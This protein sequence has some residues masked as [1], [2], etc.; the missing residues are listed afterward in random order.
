ML[1][2]LLQF[3]Q[4]SHN[5][6]L[7][8]SKLYTTLQHT[9]NF[10]RFLLNFSGRMLTCQ[11]QMISGDCIF[12]LYVLLRYWKHIL[13]QKCTLPT[14]ILFSSFVRPH[15]RKSPPPY[16]E[17]L[18]FRPNHLYTA[19]RSVVNFQPDHLYT[20]YRSMVNF[21]CTYILASAK[22]KANRAFR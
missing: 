6:W 17:G 22:R 21:L 7:R 15:Y 9:Y 2:A 14:E 10:S 3:F 13:Y 19:Y 20:K 5:I 8:W 18:Y 12:S 4:Y 16:G 11:H 1:S